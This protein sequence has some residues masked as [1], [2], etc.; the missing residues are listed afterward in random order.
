[1][2]TSLSTSIVSA[3]IGLTLAACSGA[4]S[5]PVDQSAQTE[6]AHLAAAPPAGSAVPGDEHGGRHHRGPRD[7]AELVKRFDKNGDGQLQ[8]TELPDR[9]Q[10]FM[11][12]AD[13]NGDGVLSVDELKAGQ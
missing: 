5:E 1:M 7:P 3:L 9:M 6:T 10:A 12:K 4:T 2:R 11:A 8:V 13:T